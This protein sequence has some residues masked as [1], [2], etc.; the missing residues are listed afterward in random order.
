MTVANDSALNAFESRKP[1][2]N[3]TVS[4]RVDTTTQTAKL[5]SYEL[6]IGIHDRHGNMVLMANPPPKAS[7]E[8]GGSKTS[9]TLI[10][11]AI[12]AFPQASLESVLYND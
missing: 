6:L 12:E 11:A 2:T 7:K 8:D 9:R 5:Y 3:S 4:V 10:K 1:Y